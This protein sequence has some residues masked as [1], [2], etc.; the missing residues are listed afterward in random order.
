VKIISYD[1]WNNN[2]IKWSNF[3]EVNSTYKGI[4]DDDVEDPDASKEVENKNSSD[5][6]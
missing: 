2:N 5:E 1:K 4:V 6:E 3:D